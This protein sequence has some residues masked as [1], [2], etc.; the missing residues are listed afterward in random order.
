MISYT[1]LQSRLHKRRRPVNYADRLTPFAYRIH[2]AVWLWLD[3][4]RPFVSKLAYLQIKMERDR[5][6]HDLHMMAIE[7]NRLERELRK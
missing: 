7:C 3:R 5:L 1:V 4:N 6:I 2:M